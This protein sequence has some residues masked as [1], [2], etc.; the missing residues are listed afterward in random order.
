ME[1]ITA[2]MDVVWAV[3]RIMLSMLILSTVFMGLGS[4]VDFLKG[5]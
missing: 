4:L 1:P 3:V 5:R 2:Q